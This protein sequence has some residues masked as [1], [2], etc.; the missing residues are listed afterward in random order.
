MQHPIILLHAICL[1]L[2]VAAGCASGPQTHT[3]EKSAVIDRP[4]ESTWGAL[5]QWFTSGQVQI[6]T[7]DK[8]SGVI[9][10]ERGLAGDDIADCGKRGIAT[11]VARPMS[12]NLFIQSMGA[13]KTRVTVNVSVSETRKFDTNTWQA[14]CNSTGRLEQQI[15]AAATYGNR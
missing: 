10:A 12:M 2:T 15:F 13:D 9:Y 11:A 5:M 1:G 7:I 3:F 14:P 6:K 4:Y 8:S